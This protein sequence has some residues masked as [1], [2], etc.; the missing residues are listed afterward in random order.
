MNNYQC[1]ISSSLI[2]MDCDICKQIIVDNN[3]YGCDGCIKS[4]HVGCDKKIKKKDVTAKKECNRLKL[5]CESCCQNTD[6]MSTMLRFI[7]KID[8][9][10]QLHDKSQAQACYDL[11]RIKD[12]VDLLFKKMLDNTT[13]VNPNGKPSYASV[14]KNTVKLPVIVKPKEKKQNSVETRNEITKNI[15]FKEVKTSG[16]KNTRDG[17]IIINWKV[18]SVGLGSLTISSAKASAARCTSL[19]HLASCQFSKASF[20][21]SV[22]PTFL[23]IRLWATIS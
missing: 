9:T 10:T 5:Y 18:S 2:T 4:F 16:L 13:N 15:S 23:P 8:L 6:N 7:H 3:Y 21:S 12:K 1:Y 20:C 14:A 17:E 19:K 11:E 22:T